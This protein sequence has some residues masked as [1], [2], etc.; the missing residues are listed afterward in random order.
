MPH[1]PF[2]LEHNNRISILRSHA[3]IR[4]NVQYMYLVFETKKVL[5]FMHYFI[6]AQSAKKKIVNEANSIRFVS[7]FS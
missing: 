1:V 4:L 2:H 7:R 3:K 6:S 5:I